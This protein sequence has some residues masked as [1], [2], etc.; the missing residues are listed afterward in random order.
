MRSRKLGVLL[1]AA[2]S[3]MSMGAAWAQERPRW[4]DPHA[5]LVPDEVVQ[6]GY[7]RVYR[8]EV[9]PVTPEQLAALVAAGK[10]FELD[11]ATGGIVQH[12]F[13]DYLPK[14]WLMEPPADGSRVDSFGN[15]I[16]NDVPGLPAWSQ[17][18]I[19][20]LRAEVAKHRDQYLA[21]VA[22]GADATE[23]AGALGNFLGQAVVRNIRVDD[24]VKLEDSA[25]V[26]GKV[27]GYV[28]DYMHFYE[29][30]R[31]NK[32]DIFHYAYTPT[33]YSPRV[34]AFLVAHGTSLQAVQQVEQ[35][36]PFGDR[37]AYCYETTTFA[38]GMTYLTTPTILWN[39][40]N[41]DDEQADIPTGFGMFYF[42]D[43]TDSDNNDQIRVSTDGYQTFFQQ[44]GGALNGT[45][46]QNQAIPDASAGRPDGFTAP[47]WDD[48]YVNTANGD[49]IQYKTEGA[50][51]N[52]VLT[53]EYYSVSHISSTN[54][55]YLQSR[56]YETSDVVEFHY[57]TLW[58]NSTFTSS[59]IG[60]ENYDGLSGNC[61]PVCTANNT[62]APANNYRFSYGRPFNDSCASAYQLS[63][64]STLNNWSLHRY[65]YDGDASG[66]GYGYPN[67]D[68]WFSFVAPC[69]GNLVVS[70]C[71]S[72]DG[73]GTDTII[74][75]HSACPGNNGNQLAC[76]DQSSFP[77]CSGNDSQVTVPM[78]DGQR[79][80]LRVTN[81]NVTPAWFQNGTF[82]LSL[83]FNESGAAPINDN[84]ENAFA[85]FNGSAGDQDL[86]CATNDGSSTCGS[87]GTN[88]DLWYV[89]TAPCDGTFGVTTAGSAVLSGIDTVLSVHSAIP[90]TP[91]NTIAC[92]DD[93][94]YP[95]SAITLPVTAGQRL[96]IRASHFGVA[97]ADGR[98]H[99]A[100]SYTSTAPV[101]AN[102]TCA[103]AIPIA[104]NDSFVG[105]NCGATADALAAGPCG[106][107]PNNAVW[108][109][110]VGDG[111]AFAASTCGAETNFDTLLHVYSGSCGAFV[112][113]ACNDDSTCTFS[114]TQSRVSWVTTPGVNYYILV[115]G[116]GGGS[117]TFRLTVSNGG[118]PFNDDCSNALTVPIGSYA[119]NLRC[120]TPDGS[121][122]C[123]T[124]AAN[125]SVWYRF[126]APADGT[127]VV[128][129]CGSRNTGGV[130]AGVD[131]V[132]SAFA[133]SCAGPQILCNDEG[134]TGC[135]VH[136]SR[137][138]S[139]MT[140]GQVVLVRLTHWGT[141]DNPTWIANGNYVINFSFAGCDSIDWNGDG[142][143]PDTQDITDF[144]TVFGGGFCAAPN[145]PVCNTDIDFNN[146]GLFPDTD[147]ISA[148]ITAFAGGACP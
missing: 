95:D 118:R 106:F 128:D 101:P 71:G 25:V 105:S 99:I 103:G 63:D 32:Q 39:A 91:A 69:D 36:Q 24:L 45:V 42:Y 31:L 58:S 12:T 60:M 6:N 113:V 121:S 3:A 104:C 76:N 43:C 123:A 57:S 127:L 80:Y 61:G 124:T 73:G 38:R 67:R 53:V 62:D 16:V 56:Y 5:D 93:N 146:D 74:S 92:N 120:A 119:G 112:P 9:Q 142:L 130:D 135:N 2:A 21:V 23:E 138:S 51:G 55:Y 50:V 34:A 110:V 75:A 140:A 18:D 10:D 107:V 28:I 100:F 134:S 143:F 96:W 117:G 87:S 145:P 1:A 79:V 48:M 44:G 132:L 77:G 102:D 86:G 85:V 65:T 116:W 137:I 81:Y 139:A 70:T 4:I 72:F 49:W 30:E 13:T 64:G 111:N 84:A 8:T 98:F 15:P 20:S 88:R 141:F 125:R 131:T 97:M 11:P 109:R 115:S 41:A 17:R 59:T 129:T 7:R 114:G 78:T 68:A 14:G 147:D 66:C 35:G 122:S 29:S 108:Y 54:F 22:S 19:D 89:F 37:G 47:F 82:D 133:N 33:T 83:N 40:A 94:P 26:D 126:V 52:R 46:Y 136:D 90:G 27:A 144:I 148:F